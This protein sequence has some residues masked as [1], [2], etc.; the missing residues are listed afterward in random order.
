MYNA[1]I[2]RRKTFG[3]RFYTSAISSSISLTHHEFVSI[4]SFFLEQLK[5]QACLLCYSVVKRSEGPLMTFHVLNSV[6]TVFFSSRSSESENETFELPCA[7]RT[8]SRSEKGMQPKGILRSVF[9]KFLKLSPSSVFQPAFLTFSPLR[10]DMKGKRNY[11]SWHAVSAFL[12]LC[13]FQHFLFNYM[14][15]TCVKQHA[16]PCNRS[17][18]Y[19]LLF[20]S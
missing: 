9:L 3:N 4:R 19:T 20:S 6:T 5:R 1:A 7:L 14:L 8:L 10:L 18:R 15:G 16:Y 17:Y 12:C 2:L 13:T 11:S